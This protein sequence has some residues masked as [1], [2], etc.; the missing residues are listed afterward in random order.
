M[1]AN[2]RGERRWIM[3]LHVEMLRRLAAVKDKEYRYGVANEL[4]NAADALADAESRLD[5]SDRRWKFATEEVAVKDRLYRKAIEEKADA[6]ARVNGQ[7]K[8]NARL[9]E[10]LRAY[11]HYDGVHDYVKCVLA[12]AEEAKGWLTRQMELEQAEA[13][14]RDLNDA[15][16]TARNNNDA[17]RLQIREQAEQLATRDKEVERLRA[18]LARICCG[19]GK[20]H[21]I[22]DSALGYPTTAVKHQIIKAAEAAAK[23]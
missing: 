14:V 5:D 20:P 21:A 3:S 17:L 13:S 15:L 12:E 19:L 6:E 1:E 22:A 18:E 8:E 23:E 9:C 4:R 10:L 16:E 11:R 2:L 7:E